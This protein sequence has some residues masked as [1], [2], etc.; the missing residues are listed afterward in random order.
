M[1]EIKNFISEAYKML[2]IISNNRDS[3]LQLDRADEELADYFEEMHREKKGVNSE[4]AWVSE[5]ERYCPLREAWDMED[6]LFEYWSEYW[7]EDVSIKETAKGINNCLKCM[8]SILIMLDEEYDFEKEII[9]QGTN[10]NI[11]K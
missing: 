9:R 1:E 3:I 4:D 6:I 11:E 10:E 8:D 5:D 7:E 2:D